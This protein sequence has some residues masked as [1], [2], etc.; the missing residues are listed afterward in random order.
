MISALKKRTV[1]L[2]ID[3][4]DDWR[5]I[6][7]RP[8][9]IFTAISVLTLFIL[10]AFVSDYI[11]H[12][13]TQVVI[14]SI[15]VLGQNILIGYTGLISFGQVG[16]WGV[17]AYV[18]AHS[19]KLGLI[20]AIFLAGVTAAVVGAIVGV[21]SLRLKGPYLAIATLGFSVAFFQL[22]Q[23]TPAISGG[24]MGLFIERVW[25]IDSPYELY[26]LS[27]SLCILFYLWGYRI[28]KSNTGRIFVAIRDSEVAAESLGVDVS[29]YKILSFM[30]S[31]FFTGVAGGLYAYFIG[32]LE[33]TM[34]NITESILMFSA[35]VIGGIGSVFGSALGAAFVIVIQ[36][37]FVALKE[38]IPIVFAIAI[39]LVMIFEQHGL[40]GRWIKLKLYF[41]NFPF[42]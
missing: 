27:L 21:P 34:F 32:Y 9:F 12:I 1:R 11:I 4:L 8:A 28:V 23:N 33:P 24:R 20:P 35:I 19:L 7:D 16:F 2:K 3:Y 22:V 25:G 42:R 13:L 26:C 40:Y 31:S 30:I 39:V 18:L 38:F 37:I 36:Q 41:M 15:A 29:R 6:Q 17:G 10:P 5:I 14:Y